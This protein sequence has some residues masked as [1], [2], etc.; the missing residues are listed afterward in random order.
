M[1]IT[2]EEH[3]DTLVV[4]L[5]GRFDASSAPEAEDVFRQVLNTDFKNILLDFGQVEYI[6]SGGIRAIIMLSRGCER[7]HKRMKLCSLSPFVKQVFETSNLANIFDI[8]PDRQEGLDA[9]NAR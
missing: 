1:R 8:Y 7:E 3:N 6:S 2:Q 5:E 9:F 4:G